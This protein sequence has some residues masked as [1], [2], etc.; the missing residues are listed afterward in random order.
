MKIIKW[1][2][3][4]GTKQTEWNKGMKLMERMEQN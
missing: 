4:N 2:R 1:N 3:T